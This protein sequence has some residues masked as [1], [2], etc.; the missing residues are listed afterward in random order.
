MKLK[1]ILDMETYLNERCYCRGEIY[2][3]GGFFYQLFSPD[4]ECK[5]IADWKAFTAVIVKDQIIVIWKTK[6]Q[7]VADTT[8]YDATKNNIEVVVAIAA[9]EEPDAALDTF[10]GHD[11]NRELQ[12]ILDMADA[13]IISRK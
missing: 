5:Q 8:R 6:D 11:P 13:V 10:D 1:E 4:D 7:K 2:D 12:E 3:A 9:G